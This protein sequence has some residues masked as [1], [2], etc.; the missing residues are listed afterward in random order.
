MACPG[1]RDPPAGPRWCS[2]ST[3]FAPAASNLA[4]LLSEHGGD[5]DRALALLREGAVRLPD[6][7]ELQHHFGMAAARTGDRDLA[8]KALAELN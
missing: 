7:A 8:G 5:R 2:S 1:R 6:N 3:R 4:W